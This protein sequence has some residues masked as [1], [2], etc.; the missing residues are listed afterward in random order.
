MTTQEVYRYLLT[1]TVDGQ[2]I[3][4]AINLDG[5]GSSTMV[6]KRSGE[7]QCVTAVMEG[8]Q[9][10]LANGLG[11]VPRLGEQELT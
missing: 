10:P 2:R 3:D 8:R 7:N 6:V 1:K 5:G 11:F 4:Y 9:R